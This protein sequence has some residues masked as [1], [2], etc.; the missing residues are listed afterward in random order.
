MLTR[1]VRNLPTPPALEALEPRALLSADLGISVG[2]LGTGFDRSNNPTITLPV[3]IVNHGDTALHGGGHIDYYLSTDQVLDDSDFK[4]TSAPLPK[5]GG[6]NSVGKTTLN[7]IKPALLSPPAGPGIPI[8]DYFIIAK[9]VTN[10]PGADSNPSNDAAAT[11]KTININYQFGTVDGKPRVPLTVTLSNG[12]TA[13]FAIDGVGTGQIL[14]VDHEIMVV[15]NGT[16]TQSRLLISPGPKSKTPTINGLTV[17]GSL[18]E[19]S[20]GKITIDGNVTIQGSVG[21]LAVGD[22][23][24]SSFRI[25]GLTKDVGMTFAKVTDSS[26]VSNTPIRGISVKSWRNTD[27]TLDTLAAVYITNI[28]SDGEFDASVNTSIAGPKGPSITNVKVK[29]ALANAVWHVTGDV[30]GI[31]VASIASTWGGTVTGTIHEL[32]VGGNASGSFGAGNF[33]H[34]VVIGDLVN[35]NYLA[36]TD[37]GADGKIGG[38]GNN[39]D[40]YNAGQVGKIELRGNM[41]NS[42]VAAGLKTDDDILLN[43][44]DQLNTAGSINVIIVKKSIINSHFAA[45]DLPKTVSINFKNVN[46]ANDPRFVTQIQ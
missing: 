21:V 27:S 6:A 40:T 42:V 32:Y 33:N 43:S 46:T 35:A 4:F 12:A 31:Q 25:N 22:L 9:I 17:N 34:V 20:A 39:A 14:D 16:T 11:T 45:H 18:K 8:G 1:L 2:K 36:G 15:L 44:D 38:T 19:L 41:I 23:Q 3:T 10:T 28:Q 37:L 13:T 7:T 5:L 24:Q 26:I 30:Y 29:G